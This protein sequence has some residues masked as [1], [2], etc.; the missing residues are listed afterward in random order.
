MLAPRVALV[1]T[2]RIKIVAKRR[3]KIVAKRKMKLV[4]RMMSVVEKILHQMN[5]SRPVWF[6]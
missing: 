3:M 4:T 5:N 2:R 1:T 6:R